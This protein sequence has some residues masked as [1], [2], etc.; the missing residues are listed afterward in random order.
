MTSSELSDK[1]YLMTYKN[2]WSIEIII[3]IFTIVLISILLYIIHEYVGT[4]K[5]EPMD[6]IILKADGCPMCKNILHFFEMI[7]KSNKHYFKIS[8]MD[9]NDFISSLNTEERSRLYGIRTPYVMYK[10]DNVYKKIDNLNLL[11]NYHD[12]LNKKYGKPDKDTLH[13]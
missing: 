12:Y 7:S 11:L 1:F 13:S 5:T 6:I 3:I 8:I 2:I 4:I 10:Y 9:V